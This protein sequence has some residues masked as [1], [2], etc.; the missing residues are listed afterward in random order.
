MQLFLDSAN[1]DDVRRA[2]NTGFVDGVTTNPTIISRENRPLAE[3]VGEILNVGPGLTILLEVVSKTSDEMVEEAKG[4]ADLAGANGV[5][6]LPCN[7]EGLSAVRRLRQLGIRT[8]VTLIFSVNQAIAA[9]CAGADFVA[10]FVGRLDDIDSDGVGLVEAIREVYT[11]QAVETKIIAASIRSPLSV[12]E[13][14]AVGADVI[15]LPFAVIAK[16]L[17]HPLTA[18][19]LARFDADWAKVPAGT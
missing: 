13:L 17:D 2:V 6:K 11:V 12:S 19:G 3:C 7:A 10:P 16:L 4:L 14:F 15:T 18:S 9:A 1:I 8:T 5:I